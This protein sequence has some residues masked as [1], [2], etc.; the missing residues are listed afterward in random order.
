MQT[1]PFEWT[2]GR[3]ATTRVYAAD[4][5]TPVAVPF[6]GDCE[7]C[8]SEIRSK[9]HEVGSLARD[10][11][12]RMNKEGRAFC[13]TAEVRRAL[14]WFRRAFPWQLSFWAEGRTRHYTLSR[15]TYTTLVKTF[16]IAFESAAATRAGTSR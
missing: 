11:A 16:I 12:L 14:R 6:D 8:R 3:H 7:I 9:M 4:G 1:E 15:K 5:K 2:H 13:S 10:T